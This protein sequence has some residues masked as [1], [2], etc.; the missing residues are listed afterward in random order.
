MTR[1]LQFKKD[2]LKKLLGEY[3][4]DIGWISIGERSRRKV[5]FQ[6]GPKNQLG[7]FAEKSHNLIDI[8]DDSSMEEEISAL[9][10]P[11]KDFLK[12]QEQ[13]FYTRVTI[14]LFDNGLDLVFTAKKELNFSQTQKFITFAKECDLNI[15]Y[16]VK[17]T[18]IPVLLIRNNQI[19][20]PDLKLNLDS[21]IFIQA[22]KLGLEHIIKIIRNSIKRPVNIVDIYSGFGAY[23]FAI[24]DLVKSVSS[25]EGSKKMVDLLNKNSSA[26]GLR[27]KIKGIVRDI[28]SAPI[29]AREL[30]KFDLAIINPP[31]NGA[32]PQILEIAKS[33]LKDV[34]YVSCN[35]E[36]F[37]RDAKIL[38]SAGFKIKQLTAIDQFH[39]TKHLELVA[40][41]SK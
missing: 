12:T 10:S 17:D 9:I 25:F 18:S 1:Y 23:S 36:S 8:T 21:D 34:I 24:H 41:L 6:I 29:T 19:F 22:T 14:T 38:I 30:K 40:I 15:S 28:F 7:F 37:R 3:C 39:A 16:R 2:S 35:P 32:S 26:H 27:N 31:R 13:N 20:F 33:T 11:L 4:A 5:T